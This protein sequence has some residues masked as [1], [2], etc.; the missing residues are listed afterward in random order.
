V[1]GLDALQGAVAGLGQPDGAELPAELLADAAQGAGQAGLQRARAGQRVARGVVGRQAALDP[2]AVAVKT[3]STPTAMPS[4]RSGTQTIE[5][6][7]AR[8]QASRSTRSSVSLS[9]QL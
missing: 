1:P 6:R 8:R 5:R 3:F 9:A 2:R 7:P 4:W